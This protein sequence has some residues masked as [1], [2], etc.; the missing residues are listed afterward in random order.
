MVRNAKG[1]ILLIKRGIE[2]CKGSWALPGGYVELDETIQS[3]GSRE[4]EEET[5]LSGTPGRLVGIHMQE[6]P[7]YGF[8]LVTGME[9][10]V[11]DGKLT[12][13]DDAYDA[14]F[15]SSNSM[16]EIPFT[17]HRALIREFQRGQP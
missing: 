17:S 1:E 5:G 8:V 13:G 4:L 15:F 16:P 10:I 12:A 9:F 7:T 11:K 14:A 6:S 3:S 2:P